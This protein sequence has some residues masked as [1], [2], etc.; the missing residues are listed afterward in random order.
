MDNNG[1]LYN[2]NLDTNYN[3]DKTTH[4]HMDN[5]LD[6]NY[7]PE[8]ISHSHKPHKLTQQTN[9]MPKQTMQSKFPE[10]VTIEQFANV[11]MLLQKYSNTTRTFTL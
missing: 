2:T 9:A 7:S 5:N 10:N 1:G 4:S 11:L 6:N 8:K 3:L